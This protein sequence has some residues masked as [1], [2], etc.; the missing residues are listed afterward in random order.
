[1]RL[2]RLLTLLLL[3]SLCL[4]V[5]G[6]VEIQIL[7]PQIWSGPSADTLGFL[8]PTR[9]NNGAKWASNATAKAAILPAG[10]SGQ[11]LRYNGTTLTAS[12]LFTNDG[13]N[14][15]IPSFTTPGYIAN[16]AS[17]NLSS[18]TAASIGA[19]IGA[20]KQGGNSFTANGVLGTT[21]NYP[22]TFLTNNV[23]RMRISQAGQVQ[24]NNYTSS[25]AFSGT[26][27]HFVTQSSS[28]QILTKSSAQF[29]SD[30][31][32][33]GAVTGTGSSNLVALWS[34]PSTL[35]SDPGISWSSGKITATNLQATSLN[36]AGYVTNDASGNLSTVTTATIAAA[37]NHWLLTS[38][39]V[40]RTTGAVGI[41]SGMANPTYKLQVVGAQNGVVACAQSNTA[42]DILFY[43]NSTSA[44]TG[45]STLLTSNV[46]ASTGVVAEVKN[47]NSATSTADAV[48][49][50]TV[51]GASAAIRS[52]TTR[53]PVCPTGPLA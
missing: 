19:A 31:G 28:G 48:L 1:M 49:R 15:A 3:S 34:G 38:G 44:I 53:S 16:D 6:Q 8:M 47:T 12:S 9:A 30:L 45:S 36:A 43:G 51:N 25:S 24:F 37:V 41:G 33:S 39:D 21:D 50:S 27:D 42:S 26:T 5:L 11:T 7:P 23:E 13:T 20:F 46:S 22:M 40:S 2:A 18:A 14:L 35:T 10:T 4:P 52:R 29:L 32:I 17:G